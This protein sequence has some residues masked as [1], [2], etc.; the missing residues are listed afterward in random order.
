MKRSVMWVLMCLM[1]ISFAVAAEPQ[2]DDE[3]EMIVLMGEVYKINTDL[4]LVMIDIGREDGVEPLQEFTLVRGKN[5]V[6]YMTISTVADKV[7]AGLIDT[8]RTWEAVRIGDIGL[9]RTVRKE[10]Q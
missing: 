3:P 8:S 5:I 10:A 1:C 6:G 7:A 4:N 2:N 9:T